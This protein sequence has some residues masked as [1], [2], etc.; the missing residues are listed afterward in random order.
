VL[1]SQLDP[2]TLNGIVGGAAEV[3][4]ESRA[5]VR[6][7]P[8]DKPYP[9]VEYAT[10]PAHGLAEKLTF[11]TKIT[12]LENG[13]KVGSQARYGKYCTIGVSIKSGARYENGFTKGVSHI[14]EK[15]G[16]LVR[17]CVIAV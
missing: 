15:L 11:E 10:N 17:R 7:I 4:L 2:A 8:L 9:G 16:F 1:A 13:L 5:Q 3:P 6:R 12:T 14:A